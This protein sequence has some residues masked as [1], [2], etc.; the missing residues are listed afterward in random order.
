MEHIRID[1]IE[2]AIQDIK[3]GKMVVVVDDQDRE[4]EGDIVIAAKFATPE[5][6]NF[7]ATHARG[8][9]CVPL[10]EKRCQELDLEMMV[11]KNTEQHKTAFTVS[12]DYLKDG[13][14]TGISASD[15]ARTVQALI[16]P[17]A[18]P[19]EFGRPG[20]IFPLKAK[21]GGVLRRTGHTE[22]AIDLARLA[23]YYPAG[24]LVEILNEDGTMARL[25][26][27][28]RIAQRHDLKVIS[29][30]DLVSYR[31]RHE[32]IV[33]EVFTTEMETRYGT[34]GIKLFSQITTGD[35]H[36]AVI[37]G[38]V[39]TDEPV[40]V[41]V[42]SSTLAGDLLGNLLENNGE[43]MQ[44]AMIRIAEEG[45]GIFLFMRHGD[46]ETLIQQIKNRVNQNLPDAS[47]QRD[48]GIG[49]QILRELGVSKIKLLSRHPRKRI[50]LEGYGLEIVDLVQL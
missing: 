41:R 15:R 50:G 19:D 38:D 2:E 44:Q 21:T 32:R 3:D 36:L 45:Q 33:Q 8:L 10:A 46:G 48:F 43:V 34:L 25:P 1:S 27:L 6:I 49:A 18:T 31:M 22:A 37:K 4:N 16:D 12:V 9:I 30:K 7:M 42:H 28:I 35:M 26:Q 40:L 23:G 14:T 20:H 39:H 13:C 17:T 29:I 47:P 11:G 24:V 5:I